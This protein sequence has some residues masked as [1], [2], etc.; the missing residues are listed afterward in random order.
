MVT[1][2]ISSTTRIDPVLTAFLKKVFNGVSSPDDYQYISPNK[3][4][5]RCPQKSHCKALIKGFLGFTNFALVSE[6]T[7]AISLLLRK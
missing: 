4:L 5:S 7:T 2:C 1:E 3:H 6:C